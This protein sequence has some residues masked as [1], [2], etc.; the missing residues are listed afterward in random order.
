[1]HLGELLANDVIAGEGR[2]AEF[3]ASDIE[4]ATFSVEFLDVAVGEWGRQQLVVHSNVQL[5]CGEEFL[6]GVGC[7]V[8]DSTGL[9]KRAV[10]EWD[11]LA[12]GV[13]ELAVSEPGEIVEINGDTA[14]LFKLKCHGKSFRDRLEAVV[15]LGE[16]S[17][18]EQAIGGGLEIGFADLRVFRKLRHGNDLIGRQGF[19]AFGAY[20]VEDCGRGWGWRLRARE[21]REKE[22]AKNMQRQ[23]VDDESTH[24]FILAKKLSVGL[25][26]REQQRKHTLQ[27]HTV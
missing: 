26:A 13:V 6:D 20:F 11:F 16:H 23:S 1:M 10:E 15:D 5:V 9:G 12:D 8:N 14:R 2:V 24:E 25:E 22:Q 19:Q 4:G 7:C 21:G 27:W 18:L 17:G 3:D